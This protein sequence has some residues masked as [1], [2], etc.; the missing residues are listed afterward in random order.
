MAQ[1]YIGMIITLHLFDLDLSLYALLE[2]VFS[3]Y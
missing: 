2:H 1:Y 3:L